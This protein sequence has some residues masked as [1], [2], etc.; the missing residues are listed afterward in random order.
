MYTHYKKSDF[1]TSKTILCHNSIKKYIENVTQEIYRVVHIKWYIVK[2]HIY[3]IKLVQFNQ[4]YLNP[5][6]NQQ[7]YRMFLLFNIL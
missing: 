2:S 4:T 6:P 7:R 1:R 3:Y 5:K